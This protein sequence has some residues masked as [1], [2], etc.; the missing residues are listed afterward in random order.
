[1]RKQGL[2]QII[3]AYLFPHLG[4][5]EPT[6]QR[7]HQHR[8]GR[9]S[10][11]CGRR[12]HPAHDQCAPAQRH[13]DTLDAAIRHTRALV[14]KLRALRAGLLHDLLTRGL[15]EHGEL[16]PAPEEAPDQYRDNSA[17]GRLPRAWEV[18][19]LDAKAEI[20]S[21]VTLGR[22]V[23][24]AD[25][26]ELPYLRVANVQ[27]GH[28]DLT[29]IKTVRVY[30]SEVSRFALM[31]GDV[32]LTEGGDFDKLG[33]GAVWRGQT[34]PCLHQ[35]HIFRVRPVGG[36]LHPPYFA[37]LI[38]SAYG[39]RYFLSIAK[40]TT[41]LASINSTQ[42]RAF[43][44]LRPGIEE[45]RRIADTLEAHDARVEA[46]KAELAKLEALKRGLMDDLLTGRVRVPV[47]VGEG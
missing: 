15:D 2:L 31:D 5:P 38:G 21:G 12:P 8:R 43:P 47:S 24:G 22:T 33:R 4:R 14:D 45:Q 27:D 3:L 11:R 9:V 41:N 7:Q 39:R 35:N 25:A 28:L 42:L 1:M 29:E 32:L 44:L 13:L 30:R 34:N 36:E 17:L 40:Q 10:V 23:S 46:E 16:R 19:R 6:D 37:A 18:V 20:A 26:V